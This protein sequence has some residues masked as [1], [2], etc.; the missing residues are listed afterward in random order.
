[1]RLLDADSSPT[2]NGLRER[3]ALVSTRAMYGQSY[4]F[5]GA[6]KLV[7]ARVLLDVADGSPLN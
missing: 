2:L 3:D 1:M 5:S 7:A 4:L 6:E